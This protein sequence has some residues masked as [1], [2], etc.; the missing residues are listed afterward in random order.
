[1]SCFEVKPAVWIS[2]GPV[3][4]GRC[5]EGVVRLRAALMGYSV[6]NSEQADYWISFS[7]V[8]EKTLGHGHTEKHQSSPTFS[9]SRS[10]SL[11]SSMS[12]LKTNLQTATDHNTPCCEPFP[13][14]KSLTYLMASRFLSF[15]LMSVHA[16]GDC[17][18]GGH[19]VTVLLVI[20]GVLAAK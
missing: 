19:R 17:I 2:V 18:T 3:C 5:H 15:P 4:T 8:C 10:F 13:L 7:V 11:L 16:D 14:K 9:S 20:V 12:I 6:P 1:M